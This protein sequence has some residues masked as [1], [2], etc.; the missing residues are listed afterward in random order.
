MVETL[1]Y[2]N[3]VPEETRKVCPV[4]GVSSNEEESAPN[5]SAG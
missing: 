3:P 1:V 2:E 4:I 5:D